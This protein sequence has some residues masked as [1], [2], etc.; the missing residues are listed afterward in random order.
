MEQ[1]AYANA[2]NIGKNTT[3]GIIDGI[4]NKKYSL[5]NTLQQMLDTVNSY[6]G[7]VNAKLRNTYSS[8]NKVSSAG[9]HRSG[10]TYVPY[11]GYKAVLHEGEKVLTKEEAKRSSNDGDTF[12]FYSPKAIDEKEA[13]RQ[14]KRTKQQLALDYI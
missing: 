6:M 14:M 2:K 10:L 12:V 7:K 5:R 1:D 9:S 3:Q 8:Y 4:E 13:A 11:D